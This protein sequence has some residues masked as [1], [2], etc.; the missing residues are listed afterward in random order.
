MY[1]TVRDVP[2]LQRLTHRERRELVRTYAWRSFRRPITWIGILAVLSL[3]AALEVLLLRR[4]PRLVGPH[5]P[6]HGVIPVLICELVGFRCWLQWQLVWMN[7]EIFKDHPQLCR[8]C[9][10]D[11]RVTPHRCSECGSVPTH[12]CHVPSEPTEAAPPASRRSAA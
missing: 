3:A 4:A 2:A 12:I 7:H 8:V 5:A 1:W 11:M 9:G 6:L 10:Y